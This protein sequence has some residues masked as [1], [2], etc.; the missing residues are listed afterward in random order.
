[1]ATYKEIIGTNIESRS[2]DPSNPVEGQVWYNSTTGALKGASVTTVGSWATGGNLNTGRRM[3][4]GA[5][6]SSSSAL[7]F[8]GYLGPPPNA[9]QA[10]TESYDGTSWTE[11]GDLNTARRGVKGSGTQTSAL[12][13][14]G[15]TP[16]AESAKT[17]SWNGSSWTEV[18]NLNTA[19]QQGGGAGASNT[20]A[21]FSGGA[22]FP[23]PGVFTNVEQWNGSTWTETTD[24]NSAR[25]GQQGFGIV[26]SALICGGQAPGGSYFTNT[27]VY[28][29][30]SWTEVG[31][32]AFERSFGGS[33]GYTD[34]TS[35]LIFGGYDD[36]PADRRVVNVELWN[37]SSWTEQADLSGPAYIAMAGAGTSTSA[38]AF[39]GEGPANE[40][41]TAT[42]EW[43]GAGST[44]VRTFT[45]S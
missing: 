16:S 9:A 1:M 17:D 40:L 39:G 45:T 4:G 7:G 6:V 30:S 25:Y 26:T 19:R 43:T 13:F 29:G 12:A 20:S 32:I 31:D 11:V 36:S 22:D 21:L 35:G 3:M 28:N 18:A 15:V 23:S 38:I 27:E 14:G 33:A 10:L 8:G 37:G 24:I 41:R 5:G 42:E 34:N 2:S 44:D